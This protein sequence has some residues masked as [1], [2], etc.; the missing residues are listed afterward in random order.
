M[1]LLRFLSQI[2]FKLAEGLVSEPFNK[3]TSSFSD[4]DSPRVLVD[5]FDILLLS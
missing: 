3:H 1:V 4:S 5:F 2:L